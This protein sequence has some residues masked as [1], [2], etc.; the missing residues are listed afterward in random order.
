MDLKKHA[1][2]LATSKGESRDFS[3]TAGTTATAFGEALIAAVAELGLKGGQYAREK[4]EN[5][6]PRSYDPEAAGKYLQAVSL[7]NEVFM[8]HRGTLE[9]EKG[10]V[11]LWP[12]G[13]DLAFE[14]F[15]TRRVESN[16][17]EYPAQLNL[18]FSPGE[19]SHKQP[20]FYSNPWPFEEDKLV[21]RPLPDGARWFT[22]SWKGTL[23]PYE[24]LAGDPLGEAR[25]LEYARRV[26]ELASPTLMA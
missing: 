16:G 9:G 5:D 25:L 12:H 20:Y 6:A 26:Y 22:K 11:Q 23:L 2:T 18:G 13:F 8:Q 21:G 4:F 24:E 19:S 3:M 17:K 14:W 1:V 10:P 15:G 7:A